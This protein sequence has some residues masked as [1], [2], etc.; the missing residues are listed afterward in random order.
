MRKMALAVVWGAVLAFP[1]AGQEKRQT[2]GTEPEVSTVTIGRHSTFVSGRP[3]R[4]EGPN[5]SFS[6]TRAVQTE[7][8]RLGCYD[9]EANGHWS[10]ARRAAAQRF[11]ERVN[12]RLPVDTADDVMLAL[13]QGQSGLVCGQCPPG[14]ELDA[15]S[16]CIP[17]AL[18]K[19]PTAAVATGSLASRGEPSGWS[20]SDGEAA[21]QPAD[22]GHERDGSQHA[23]PPKKRSPWQK[24]IRSVDKVL[25]L[26]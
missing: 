1:A 6:V 26:N 17:T 14:Q 8:R 22:P 21:A 9:G 7:L 3:V 5:D 16:R 13:L 2:T 15:A 18:V 25:G 19:R 12:A 20:K 11:L 23:Q 24:L 4:Q 10:A